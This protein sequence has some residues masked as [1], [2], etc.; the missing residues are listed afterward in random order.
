MMDLKEC[1]W[2]RKA[3]TNWLRYG[4]QNSKC[5]HCHATER[6]KRNFILG[7]EDDRGLWVENKDR[8]GDLLSSFYSSL[9]SF[10]SPTVFDKVLKG[11]ETQVTQEM[12][13]ELL[14][15]FEASEVQAALVQMK[16]NTA[17]DPDGLPPLFYK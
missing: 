4:D 1:M 14:Q 10:S 12:N 13:E 9:F 2:N 6:S 8:I 16:A 3:K 15:S 5:F 7:L 17:L 11:V